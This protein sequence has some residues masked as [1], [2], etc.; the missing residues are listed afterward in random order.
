M[1]EASQPALSA[2]DQAMVA[3]VDAVAAQ[4]QQQAGVQ[5]PAQEAKPAAPQRPENVPEKFWDAEKGQ[6]NT[7]ALLKSY[8]ELEAGKNKPA[9]EPPKEGEKGTETTPEEAAKALAD[10]KVDVEAMSSRF[11]QEGKLSDDD[12]TQLAKAGFGKE[13]VDAYIAGQEALAAQRDSQGFQ[14][15]GGQEQYQAMAQWA[16]ANLP[17]AE[18]DAFNESVSGSPAQMKQAILGLKAQYEAAMGNDPKLI[19][20]SAGAESIGAFGSR[21]EMTAAMRDPR[22]RADPAYRAEVERRVGL[23]T[24]F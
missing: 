4:A 7:E 21:A 18:R 14:L 22:Y 17:Q 3:K 19:K 9:A 6:V 12:Y 11:A 15:A 8:G 13:V 1:P 16:V 2:H 5:P 20:G 24:N 10:A 23:M